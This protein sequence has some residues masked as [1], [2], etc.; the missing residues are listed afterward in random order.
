MHEEVFKMSAVKEKMIEVIQKQPDDSSYDEIFRELA[1]GK[2]IERGLSD[3]R[4]GK[5]I[6]NE[7]MK[8]R[9][10]KWQI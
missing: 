10:A 4:E 5:T 6:S 3:S 1:F 7:D 2:I 8:R 9:I